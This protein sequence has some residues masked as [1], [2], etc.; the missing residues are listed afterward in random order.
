MVDSSALAAVAA[1]LQ[2]KNTF[3]DFDSLDD[4]EMEI[5]HL[6][7]R[8]LS[9]PASALARQMTVLQE[10]AQQIQQVQQQAQQIQQAQQQIQKAQQVQAL[11]QAQIGYPAGEQGV[12]STLPSQPRVLTGDE[13]S[14]NPPNATTGGCQMWPGGQYFLP[15]G[16]MPDMMATTAPFVGNMVMPAG[17]PGMMDGCS[18][19][20]MPQGLPL[21]YTVV[22]VGKEA[23]LAQMGMQM[24]E[25]YASGG[26]DS[27]YHGSQ[28]AVSPDRAGMAMGGKGRPAKDMKMTDTGSPPKMPPSA[29][30]PSDWQSVTTVMLRNLPNKYSQQ[31]LLEELNQAGFA[32]AYDFMY[33]PI[34]PETHANRGYAFINFVS[35]DFAWMARTTYE[36][37][38]MGKFNSEKLVS[39]VPA[40]LQGFEANY[41]HYSTARVNR[42]PAETRPVFLR[43]SSMPRAKPE[44]KRGGRRNQGSLI[45]M[46]ARQL[47][48]KEAPEPQKQDQGFYVGMPGPKGAEKEG[49]QEKRFCPNCGA[50]AQMDHRFCQFCGTPLGHS[51]I[52]TVWG[53]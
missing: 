34:D 1:N 50:E 37:Q 19:V 42:G 26:L 20:G 24:P 7:R 21:Q 16:S 27:G 38:K 31:M 13:D 6:A 12:P 40:A 4:M 47:T 22:G 49:E 41:S 30:I 29:Q 32:G 3:L 44:R 39:V 51:V 10:Q 45:D 5:S 35:P 25:V 14:S 48:K 23:P 2:V 43:E 11:A 9:E 17:I 46:A 15:P 33:L 53:A 18:G 8:Q 36:G 52:E 28:Q